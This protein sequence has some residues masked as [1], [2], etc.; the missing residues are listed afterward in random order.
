MAQAAQD[1]IEVQTRTQEVGDLFAYEIT[2]PVDVGRGRSALVPILQAKVDAERVI[3]YNREVREKNPMSA[4][5]IQN[6]TGLTLEGGPVTVFEQ[7]NYVGEAML[8]TMRR[9]EKRIVP[10]S[11]ELG[12][13]V[14]QQTHNQREYLQRISKHGDTIHK[15][16]RELLITQYQLQSRLDRDVQ[17]YLDHHPTYPTRENTPEPVEVTDNF[18]RFSFKNFE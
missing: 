12:V 13:I 3:L 5:R 17:S 14:K 11:V 15:Y 6:N 10:Y 2:H 9:D 7:G 4:F 18:W 16:F 1:S 8:D